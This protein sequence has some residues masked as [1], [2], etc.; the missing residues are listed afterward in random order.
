MDKLKIFVGWDSRE[1]I[2]YQ[3]CKFSI[4]KHSSVPVDVS[5]LKQNELRDVGLYTR[6][7]DKLASTE[8]TFT[9][10]YIPYLMNFKGWAIFC[11]CDFLWIEDV[12]K[13]LSLADDKYAVQVVKH[14]Y[15][16]KELI[17]MDNKEQF[18]Y[19]RKNWSSL[20]LWNCSHP[21]N[22]ILTPDLLNL[23][24]GSFLHQ[25]KWLSDSEIGEIPHNWNWLEGWYK[26]PEDGK[27]YAVHYTRGRPMV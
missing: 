20:I 8:F 9:R 18:L 14:D 21:S 5:A 6:E 16:P 13:L 24:S 19:P 22:A 23:E 27:P 11:D 17:K 7:I 26:E 1:D 3:V 15:Q 12:E 25:F 2:A 10:F 4:E